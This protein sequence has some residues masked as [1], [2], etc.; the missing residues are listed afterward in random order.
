MPQPRA[1][2]LDA[3]TLPMLPFATSTLRD[4]IFPRPNSGIILGQRATGNGQLDLLYQWPIAR[5]LPA[6][7]LE[8]NISI[9]LYTCRPHH[10]YLN[11]STNTHTD[12]QC[13]P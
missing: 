3:S 9:V 8:C 7:L 4:D 6:R 5:P 13:R 1:A 12:F 11:L 2:G 10:V